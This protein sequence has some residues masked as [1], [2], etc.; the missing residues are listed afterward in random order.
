MILY[1]IARI[2][3]YRPLILRA[4]IF[5]MTWDQYY[6]FI[7]LIPDMTNYTRIKLSS[8]KLHVY[9]KVWV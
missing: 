1:Q 3:Y 2:L 5:N 6:K 8:G 4:T 7:I 9:A